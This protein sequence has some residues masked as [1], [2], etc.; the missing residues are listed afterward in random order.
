[1]ENGKGVFFQIQFSIFN[2][3]FQLPMLR[4]YRA[5]AG[6]GKTF[7]LTMEYFKI[8]FNASSE[9][10]NVLAVTFTNKATEEMKSRIVRELNKLAEGQKSDYW[11]ELKRTLKLTDEQVRERAGV[12][13]T[14]ILHDYGRLSVTTIDRFFQRVIKAFT[15]EL[16]IFP[17]YNVELDSDYVLQRAVDQVMQ[18]MNKDKELRAWITELM[19]DSVEDAKSWSVK[20]KIAELGKELFGESY[21]LFDKEVRDKFNDR[22][23]LRGYK[24][25]LQGVISRFED[26]MEMFGLSACRYIEENGLHEE[27]FKGGKRSFIN[28]FYKLRDKSLDKIPD[29]VRKAIDNLDEWVTKKGSCY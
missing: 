6:A 7:A 24:I 14:L 29:S 11:E 28:Y 26:R 16:G 12:L 17:G 2:F 27:D 18:R 15:R 3:Q 21:M 13:R 10:K 25:F 5:S 1:M 9:Y 8:V 23:F 20:S 22:G 19:S 4:V